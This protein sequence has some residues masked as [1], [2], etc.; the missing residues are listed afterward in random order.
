LIERSDVS[1]AIFEQSPRHVDTDSTSVLE[2]TQQWRIDARTRRVCGCRLFDVAWP[3]RVAQ[4]ESGGLGLP[5]RPTRATDATRHV[6]MTTTGL[7]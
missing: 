6:I 3:E 4:G 1:A 5:T 7:P 2:H